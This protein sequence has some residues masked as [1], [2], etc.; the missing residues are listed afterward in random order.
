MPRFPI[1]APKRRV[2]KALLL[3]GFEI[4]REGNHIAMVRENPDGSP[5]PRSPCRTTKSSRAPPSAPS[6]IRQES[7]DKTSSMH[8]KR[9]AEGSSSHFVSFVS[10]TDVV[11]RKERKDHTSQRPQS[12]RRG[13]LDTEKHR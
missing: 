12:H 10:P 3:L 5:A 7:H 6:A 1:D 13:N 8:T 2:I 9:P 11:K 4:V